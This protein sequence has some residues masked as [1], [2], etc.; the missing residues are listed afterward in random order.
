MRKKVPLFFAT[1]SVILIVAV[2]VAFPPTHWERRN[3]HLQTTELYDR[4]W[5]LLSPSEWGLLPLKICALEGNGGRSITRWCFGF[6]ALSETHGAWT[7][8]EEDLK[9]IQQRSEKEQ[10]QRVAAGH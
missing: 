5:V 6:F 9:R 7:P 3:S 2:A 8:S 10:K 4:R 1:A